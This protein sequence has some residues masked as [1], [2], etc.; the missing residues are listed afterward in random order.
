MR[1]SRAAELANRGLLD[2]PRAHMSNDF[3]R[4]GHQADYEP[5]GLI[6]KPMQRCRRAEPPAGNGIAGARAARSGTEC[7]DLTTHELRAWH[8]FVIS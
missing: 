4:A 3:P 1:L 2:L 5:S 8:G 7:S 6:G